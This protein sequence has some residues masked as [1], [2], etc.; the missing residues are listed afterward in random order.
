MTDPHA[1]I[2]E[3]AESQNMSVEAARR[4]SLALVEYSTLQRIASECPEFT[5]NAGNVTGVAVRNKLAELGYFVGKVGVDTLYRYEDGESN[6]VRTTQS[7][8]EVSRREVEGHRDDGTPILGE[9]ERLDNP[10]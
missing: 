7:Y 9:K 5:A 6:P 1:S 4:Q 10:D 8:T 3:T 2:E